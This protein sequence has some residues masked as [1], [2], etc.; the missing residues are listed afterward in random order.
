MDKNLHLQLSLP[1]FSYDFDLIQFKEVL[2]SIGIK[3][4]FDAEEANFNNIITKENR[5]K[6]DMGNLY[7]DTAIHKTY[8]DLN[9]KGTKAAAVTYFG[10]KDASAIREE[11]DTVSVNFNKPFIYMIRD[12]SSKEILLFG[13]VETPN[14]WKG[15]TCEEE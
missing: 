10:F 3:K 13:V 8:I 12:T 2:E 15:T 1:R 4:M 7:I 5:K 11:F 6:M 9:E 14:K